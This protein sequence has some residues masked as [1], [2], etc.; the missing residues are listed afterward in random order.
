M[1]TNGNLHAELDSYVLKRSDELSEMG[2]HAVKMQKSLRELVEQDILTKLYNR[3]SG[4]K[5]ARQIQDE[6]RRSGI[7]FCVALGDV[8]YFKKVN[9]TYGHECGDIVLVHLADQLKEHMR[10]RGFAARWGGEE[11]LLVFQNSNLEDTVKSVEE[12]ME[13]IRSSAIGYQN[14]KEI[15]IT[16]TFGVVEGSEDKIDHI[17]R[18]S[19]TKLYLG[20]KQG[21]DQI[22]F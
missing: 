20:K 13:N 8:D 11:F 1:V 2:K 9:D 14:E 17:I 21:R 22:V 15:H 16:M 7:P 6:Y 12:L 19:D 18:E 3:R 5:M 4:E 10:R